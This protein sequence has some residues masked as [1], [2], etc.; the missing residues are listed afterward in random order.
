VDS[1]LTRGAYLR[2]AA[3][4]IALAAVVA[5]HPGPVINTG[6]KPSNVGG[7]ISGTVRSDAGASLA[8]RMVTVT[9]EAT[10]AKLTTSTSS[11]GGYTIQVPAGKYRLDLE[12][13]TGETL[14][15]RP[16]PTDVN[17]GDLDERRDFIVTVR[18]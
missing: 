15:T 13:H 14:S 16:D 6:D 3:L 12:L 5:C 2:A 10:G 18:P 9:N 7:T 8:G 4:T 17:V 1:L 11:S